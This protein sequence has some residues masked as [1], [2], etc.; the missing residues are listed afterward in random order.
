LR[1]AADCLARLTVRIAR[2][3]KLC[4][5]VIGQNDYDREMGADVEQTKPDARS[6]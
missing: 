2:I 3:E 4:P 6:R 5:G 1:I